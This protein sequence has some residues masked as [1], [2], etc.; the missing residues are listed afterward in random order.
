MNKAELIEAIANSTKMTKA[1][2]GRAL[3][4]TIEAISKALKKGDRLSLVGFGSFSVAKRAARLGRNPQTGKEIK[5]A[6]KKVVKFK[7][8]TELAT[9]VNKGK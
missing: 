6:A 5:I 1:D 8:G 3:D 4:A 2:S 7:A 9:N